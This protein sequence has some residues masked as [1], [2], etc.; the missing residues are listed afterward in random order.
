MELSAVAALSHFS[1]FFLCAVGPR[2]T[3]CCRC[4]C[5]TEVFIKCV[6]PHESINHNCQAYQFRRSRSEQSMY[7]GLVDC[8]V[9]VVSSCSG[10]TVEHCHLDFTILKA[11]S[12]GIK[13]R[14]GREKFNTA[15][16]RGLTKHEPTAKVETLLET[17][18][19]HAYVSR[20]EL[21]TDSMSTFHTLLSKVINSSG[22]GR[23]STRNSGSGLL[24]LPLR[25]SALNFASSNFTAAILNS[26]PIL[27]PQL[28]VAG[29][30]S[31]EANIPN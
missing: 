5:D 11:K 28:H 1:S 30:N 8:R 20:K 19:H 22:S 27:R 14:W 6:H 12:C 25:G 2:D 29:C 31:M 3:P 15:L 26:G 13:Q 24:P 10:R 16:F 7:N 23:N 4:K 18:N 21:I 17:S 9:S